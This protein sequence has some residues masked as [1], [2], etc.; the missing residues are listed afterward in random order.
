MLILTL[1][2]LAI[3]HFVADLYL[4]ALYIKPSQKY[5]YFNFKSHMH[6]LHHAG[7]TAIIFLIVFGWWWAVL[8]MVADYLTL[9]LCRFCPNPDASE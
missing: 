2:L 4:Q 7:L 3:K 6:Y 1:F 5:L 8:C 9:W